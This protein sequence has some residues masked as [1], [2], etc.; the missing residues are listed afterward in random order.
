MSTWTKT[1]NKEDNSELRKL[2][3]VELEILK[4]FSQFCEE[5]N[6]RYY[7]I[8]GTMLGAI[9]HKEFIPWDDDIDIGMP[10]PDYEKFIELVY[11]K[12]PCNFKLLNY[13]KTTK[14]AISN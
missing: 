7:M 11:Y 3:L 13:K 10:R 9:R 12:L 14:I 1:Y 4:F 8:G 5:N 2:Q 6:L